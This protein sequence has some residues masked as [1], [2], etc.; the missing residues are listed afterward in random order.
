M[1]RQEPFVMRI[2]PICRLELGLMFNDV[3]FVIRK[4]RYIS[5]RGLWIEFRIT[6]VKVAL[7]CH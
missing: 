1:V 5:L 4:L 7:V 6:G 3:I 2:Y